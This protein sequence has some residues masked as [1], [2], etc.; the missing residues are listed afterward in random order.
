MKILLTSLFFLS[1]SL[2]S[3]AQ[4]RFELAPPLIKYS[5][6]F[7]TG[8][9][10][11]RIKFAQP[12]AAA[13]YTLNGAEPTEKSPV[14]TGVVRIRKNFTV[15]KTKAFGEGF[16]PS[17]S[18]S[19]TFIKDGLQVKNTVYTIP[20]SRYPGNGAGALTDNLG[21]DELLSAA[22]WLGYYC[23]TVNVLITLAKK[24]KVTEVLINFLQNQSGW[25]FLPEKISLEY[26]DLRTGEYLPA[27]EE[28]L[29]E[30]AESAG[31]RCVYQRVRLKEKQVTDKIMVHLY[32]KRSIPA[33]HTA[34]GSHAWMFIDELK[35]Y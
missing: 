14:S 28:I 7:F 2:S 4:A 25:I 9:A 1:G 32:V 8:R 34:K 31:S 35:V 20:D 6:V 16:L 26:D 12:G 30:E 15:L 33:W 13:H 10:E 27:G 23:D 19:V 5:S 24:Q 17:A 3:M 21:G 22:T 18:T 29:P 11:A